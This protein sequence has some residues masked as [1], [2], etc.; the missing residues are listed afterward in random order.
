M[1]NRK[2]STRHSDVA[3]MIPWSARN[4]ERLGALPWTTILAEVGPV[5]TAW[6][7]E[8]PEFKSETWVSA[9]EACIADLRVAPLRRR[10]RAPGKL[11]EWPLS[12][13]GMTYWLI[14]E[15]MF[16]GVLE[17]VQAPEELRLALETVIR[18]VA[19]AAVTEPW[20]L[21]TAETW[22]DMTTLV[23]NRLA[24]QR[25][26]E[27]LTRRRQ[28]FAVLYL[29]LDGF[30]SVN[31]TYGHAAGDL[32]LETVAERW[33]RL[34]RD[35]DWLGRWGG[36]EFL[37]IIPDALAQEAIG[38]VGG[39]IREACRHPVILAG[40]RVVSLSVS[41]GYAI[42][43]DEGA[44]VTDLLELADQRLYAAK[45]FMAQG[46][47]QTTIDVHVSR[48]WES[49]IERAIQEHRLEVHYQPVLDVGSR[50]PRLWEAFVRYRHRDQAN[51]HL[52][53]EFLA[54]LAPEAVR[55]LDAT[56]LRRV[57]ADMAMWHHHGY[58]GSVAVNVDPLSLLSD[59]WGTILRALHEEFPTVVPGDIAFEIGEAL[60]P[61]DPR[62]IAIILQ[63]LRRQGY[64][65]VLDDYGSGMSPLARFHQVPAE[66][67]KIDASVTRG[68]RTEEG[69]QM[70]EAVVGLSRPFGFRAVAEGVETREQWQALTA[71]G[72]HGGQGWLFSPAI[73]AQGVAPW[74]LPTE[75]VP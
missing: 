61:A 29:D 13:S 39:R 24:T 58:H 67:V 48:A 47:P 20:V 54:A 69:R 26:L 9:I 37:V 51:L 49:R 2:I 73:S 64:H 32:V 25:H 31:D 36:D 15:T 50:V 56:V 16:R 18:R 55:D 10:E 14:L 6:A 42:F 40:G 12:L 27:S 21:Q 34:M 62:P 4:G 66:V 52:P 53:S 68:W 38:R 19:Q 30:K 60:I 44:N 74:Q 17:A 45:R 65:V 28:P 75:M 8:H 3:S 11:G 43:P 46:V 57:F 72:C 33:Q 7:K 41:Y 5:A 1:S 63:Q 70:I 35:S 71:W 59:D 23:A 22:R